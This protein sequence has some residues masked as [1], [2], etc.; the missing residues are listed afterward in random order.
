M[1]IRRSRWI[2][3]VL[4]ALFGASLW[5]TVSV[6][7]QK[8]RINEAYKHAQAEVQQLE[9][10]RAR[11]NTELSSAKETVEGQAGNI[12]SL[13]QELKTLQGRLDDTAVQLSTLQREHEQLRQHNASMSAQLESVTTEK[14]QL[15]SKL[16]NLKELKLAI[17]NVKH[18]MWQQRLAS[19][20]AYIQQRKEVDQERLASGNRGYVMRNGTSTLGST[21]RLQVHVLEPQQSQ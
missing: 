2:V 13:E 18:K 9:E 15:E 21:K 12:S 11:L 10:E 20:R 4:I 6:E 5:R 14:Q 8:R 3:V 1:A 16:S 17:R 7:Q 19:W